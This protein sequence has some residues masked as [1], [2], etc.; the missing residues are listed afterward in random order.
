MAENLGHALVCG[1]C[2]D[3]YPIKSELQSFFDSGVGVTMKRN[4]A[5]GVAASISLA[6]G[7]LV[8]TPSTAQ[9]TALP[10]CFGQNG[11]APFET[12]AWV[13]DTKP[14]ADVESRISEYNEYGLAGTWYGPK[15]PGESDVWAPYS[16][17]P[18]TYTTHAWRYKPN[19][20][21]WTAWLP[22]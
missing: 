8:S 21:S 5:L 3:A 13:G 15:S 10:P 12:A 7:A 18:G 9:A 22:S 19:G 11:H 6:V 20:G 17:A 16:T 14:C 4:R 2:G 1:T